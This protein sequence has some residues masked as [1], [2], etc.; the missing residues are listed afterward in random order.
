M[1]GHPH[2]ESLTVTGPYKAAGSGDT[3]SRRHIFS[4]RPKEK[5]D[6]PS[7]EELACA[8]EIV[9]RLARQ[10]YRG[11]ATDK[12]VDVLMDFFMRGR[13]RNGFE[14]GI[15]AAV[16]R[17]LA[18][19]KFVFRTERDTTK[20]GLAGIHKISDLEL[21][22]RLSFFLWSSIPDETLLQV[23]DKGG[24][25]DPVTLDRQVAR[26]LA[27]PK[28]HALVD[29][30]ASQWL[31]LRNLDSMVPSSA[32]FPDFDDNLR[33]AMRTETEMFFESIVQ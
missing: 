17:V 26:M 9:A 32:A 31:Y 10:A 20:S 33:Q 19:P 8:H 11:T 29:N 21:A 23:A 12:D 15:Q 18:S 5:T 2:L 25:S 6:K 7:A 22:S 16:E 14:S 30:F 1:T 27:D 3:P 13:G 4:C 28:A 24:L